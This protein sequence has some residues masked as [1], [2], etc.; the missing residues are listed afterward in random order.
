MF[1]LFSIVVL[2]FSAVIHEYMHG[3]MADRLG[4]PTAKD[5]GRLTLN[6]LAHIDPV[7]SILVPALLVFSN[8]GFVLGWA[9]PVP[10]NPYNLKDPKYG[11][12]KVAVAGPLGNLITAL[13]FGFVLRFGGSYLAGIN[14]VFNDFLAIIIY[15][16]VLL[17]IFNLV[18][19][20]PMD[21]S[22]VL[23]PFLPYKW[24]QKYLSLERY[25]MFLVL[26]F[27]MLGFPLI[28]PIINFLFSLIIGI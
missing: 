17:M 23:R 19:I 2:V 14:P 15:I 13:F 4:D 28:I 8:A 10:Y 3:W 21:G 16:N 25:G 26:A 20:P 24:Q 7:G 5:L 9:K 6:P 11:D 27:V 12:A 1:E 18:P 22:K